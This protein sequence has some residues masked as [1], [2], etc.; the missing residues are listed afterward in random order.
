MGVSIGAAMNHEKC[1]LYEAVQGSFRP[2]KF[3]AIRYMYV[4]LCLCYST[5]IRTCVCRQ[6]NNVIA[7]VRTYH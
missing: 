3:G 5:Y 1:Y 2:Q 7:V 6:Y 4:H